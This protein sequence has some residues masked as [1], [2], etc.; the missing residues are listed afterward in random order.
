M[1]LPKGLIPQWQQQQREIQSRLVIQPFSGIPRLVAGAGIAFTPDGQ[2]A[3]AVAVVYDLQSRQII[4]TQT[5]RLPVTVPYIPGYLSFRESPVLLKTVRLLRSPWEVICL[6]GQG[7]AHP[8]RCGLATH[9]GITLDRPAIGVGKSRLIGEF[10][11]PGK[12]AGSASPL[13][14]AGEQIGLVLRTRTAVKPVFVSI[15]HK[16]DLDSARRIVLACS[17]RYRIPEPTRQADLLT[18]K[19]RV[20]YPRG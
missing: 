5:A 10:T 12:P 4:E 13:Y 9:M 16:M 20:N 19:Y 11:E 15:G 7:Y 3:V 1:K 14:D 17:P 2:T 8:R 18:K 6:D